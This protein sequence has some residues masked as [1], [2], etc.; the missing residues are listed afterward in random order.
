MQRY[1][2][3]VILLTVLLLLLMV[4]VNSDSDRVVLL[5][6]MVTTTYAH[7]LCIFAVDLVQCS[8]GTTTVQ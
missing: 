6:R 8:V 3:H 2:K 4:V 7:M 1:G 5:S